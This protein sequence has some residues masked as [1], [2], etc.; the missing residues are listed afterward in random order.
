MIA[1]KS[2]FDRN[3]IK[4]L[5]VGDIV[6]LSGTI[7]TGRD[8]VCKYLY[9]GHASPLNLMAKFCIMPGQWLSKIH[10]VPMW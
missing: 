8:A 10:Q 6:H 2:P 4:K 3:E 1:L 7:I 5:R 9:A